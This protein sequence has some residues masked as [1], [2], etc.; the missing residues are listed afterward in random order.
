M[1]FVWAFGGEAYPS[2]KTFAQAY[3]LFTVIIFVISFLSGL[4]FGASIITLLESVAY[5]VIML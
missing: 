1:L 3:L 2:R 4:V 5:G